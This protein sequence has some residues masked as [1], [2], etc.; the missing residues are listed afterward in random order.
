MTLALPPQRDLFDIPDDIAYLNCSYMAPQLRSVTEAGL[1]AVRAKAQPWSIAAV[2]FFTQVEQLRAEF[3]ALIGADTD[4]IALVPSVSYG[5]ATAAA[6]LPIPEGSTIVTMAEEFPS[7]VYAWRQ[8]AA[9]SGAEVLTASPEPHGDWT[10]TVLANITER[11]AIVAVPHCHW[12]DG[13]MVDLVAVGAAARAVGAALV[14]D[15]SQS[16]GAAPLDLAAV[17]PDFLVAVGYKWLLGPYSLGYLY[18]DQARRGGTPLEH[19]WIAR[20]GSEDFTRL[21]DYVDEF[22]PGAR[23]FDVGERSN[24][25]LV[26]MAL[27]A[28]RQIASWTVPAIAATISDLTERIARDARQCGYFA[29]A[30]R[31]PM[32]SP[33]MLGLRAESGVPP[34]LAARLAAER[35]HV[36]VR[37]D[38]IRVS[39]H[40]YNTD[41]DVDRLIAALR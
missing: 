33:H 4:G 14:V 2:D 37:G 21:V 3:A 22:Q 29:P 31:H 23:R 9:A 39:P 30:R 7:N 5:I 41:D 16:L 11:T 24:F 28:I 15:A 34:G 12:T 40:V 25:V 1:A 17:R 18:V 35:V 13:S 19:N 8:A 6:N 20:L 27:A 10:P 38:S 36:S 32:K 26:P